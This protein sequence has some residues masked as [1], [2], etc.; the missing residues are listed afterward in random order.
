MKQKAKRR[1]RKHTTATKV[2][3]TKGVNWNTKGLTRKREPWR[4]HIE[5][6]SMK[7]KVERNDI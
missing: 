7:A 2:K 6:F 3:A 5:T 1:K 4:T